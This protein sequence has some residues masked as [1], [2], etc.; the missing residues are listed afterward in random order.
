MNLTTVAHPIARTVAQYTAI[1]LMAPT[2][3][4]PDI[5][6]ARMI[7]FTINRTILEPQLMKKMAYLA[8]PTIR[9]GMPMKAS[10][11]LQLKVASESRQ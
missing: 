1:I 8:P 2:G 10:K 3:V 5:I 4:P 6:A 9:M 7:H 11:P